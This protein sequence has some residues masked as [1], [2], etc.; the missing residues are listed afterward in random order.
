[1]RLIPFSRQIFIKVYYVQGT[2]L[3]SRDA[4]VNKT[5][6]TPALVEFR[7]ILVGKGSVFRALE[8]NE[9][10]KADSGRQIVEEACQILKGVGW[11]WL[12]ENLAVE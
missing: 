9:S 7:F 1:M 5:H 6:K 10:V 12:R 8:K 2:A 4:T 11:E 3:S